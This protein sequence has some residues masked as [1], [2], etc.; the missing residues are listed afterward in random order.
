MLSQHFPGG[1]E[2]NDEEPSISRFPN[3]SQQC[4]RLSQLSLV[5]AVVEFGIRNLALYHDFLSFSLF[6][7]FA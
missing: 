7:F 1:T 4:Y 2:E 3:T 5:S 6:P